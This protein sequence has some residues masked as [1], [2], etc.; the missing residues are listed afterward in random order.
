M[1]RGT[2]RGGRRGLGRRMG[3]MLRTR[4]RLWA[5]VSGR[6]REVGGLDWGWRDDVGGVLYICLDTR[7]YI[8]DRMFLPSREMKV[9]YFVSP[10]PSPGLRPLLVFRFLVVLDC[11]STGNILF[12][13]FVLS[14][15]DSLSFDPRGC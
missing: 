4:R 3:L 13:A 12:R 9:R 2:S 1:R 6:R 14:L 11:F 10:F 15:W 7:D 5:R 8:G